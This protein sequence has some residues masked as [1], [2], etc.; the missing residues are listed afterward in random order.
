MNLRPVECKPN[1]SWQVAAS[2]SDH[3]SSDGQ[4]RQ[5]CAGGSATCFQVNAFIHQVSEV[6]QDLCGNSPG[7][8]AHPRTDSPQH[9]DTYVPSV[10]GAS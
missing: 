5:R 7:I 8:G 1:D 9:K 10:Q 4:Q 3:L 2:Q 6:P